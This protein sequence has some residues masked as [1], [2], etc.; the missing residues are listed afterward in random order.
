MEHAEIWDVEPPVGYGLQISTESYVAALSDRYRDRGLVRAVQQSAAEQ[1]QKEKETGMLAP[2]SYRLSTLSDAAIAGRYR[3][4][5]DSMSAA[6]LLLYFKETRRSRIRN[7]DFSGNTGIDECAGGNVKSETAVCVKEPK[8]DLPATL[9]GGA[10][11]I[12]RFVKEGIPT[13]FDSAKPDTS[14][15]Q[16]RFP[17]SA[18]AALLAIAASL[19]LIVSSSVLLTRAESNI[20]SL[21]NEVSAVSG[22]VAELKSDFEV[23]IDLLEIRKIAMEEYGMVEEDYVKMDYIVLGGEETVE[24]F[25]GKRTESVGLPALLSGIGIKK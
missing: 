11:S 12:A 16:K 7:A 23:Q 3:R 18:F 2:D 10:R 4:G 20:S 22:E 5:K 1:I 19:M 24:V 25:D 6:D 15:N 17:L 14:S 9:S 21:K 13:W 8:N